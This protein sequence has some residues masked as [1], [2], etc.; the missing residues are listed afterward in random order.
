[1]TGEHLQSAIVNWHADCHQDGTG[2]ITYSASGSAVGPYN[3]TFKERG[4]VWV[5]NSG[6]VPY[7][8]FFAA[9]EIRSTSPSATIV[10]TKSEIP[11]ETFPG[12][13]CGGYPIYGY[14][15]YFNDAP[16]VYNARIRRGENT[17]K[18]KGTSNV[19]VTFGC[20]DPACLPNS[21]REDFTSTSGT[22]LIA[23]D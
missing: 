7:E 4:V 21:I 3:G 12:L 5:T 14:S 1:M 15:S 2:R 6:G 11:P 19:E 9:F 13:Y 8:N 23:R 10:G 16:N 20:T 22:M 18:D 17:F